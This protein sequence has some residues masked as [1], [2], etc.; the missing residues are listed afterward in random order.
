MKKCKCKKCGYEW[1]PRDPK[2][3]PKECP[4]CKSRRWD[5]EEG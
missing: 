3:N 5:N 4:N 2:I 1:Y